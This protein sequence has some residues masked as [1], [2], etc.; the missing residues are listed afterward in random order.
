M[1]MMETLRDKLE[2]LL[3]GACENS[4]LSRNRILLDVGIDPAQMRAS[5]SGRRP[6]PDSLL[7]RLAES[8]YIDV[9]LE[10][11]KGWR[12][13]DE[14]RGGELVEALCAREWS[15]LIEAARQGKVPKQVIAELL[16]AVEPE[17]SLGITSESLLEKLFLP[18]ENQ[19]EKSV[20][21]FP[22]E[23]STLSQ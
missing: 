14:Y 9:S 19:K 8:A 10:T 20:T 23:K 22:D 16:K 18:I 4:G 7:E 6:V 2:A 17:V 3:K 12:A 5:L 13:A 11:L 1:L 21:T 15:D